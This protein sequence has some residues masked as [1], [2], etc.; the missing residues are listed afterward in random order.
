[1]ILSRAG[2]TAEGLSLLTFAL[3]LNFLPA[4]LRSVEE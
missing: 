1:M 2:L 3:S 4:I